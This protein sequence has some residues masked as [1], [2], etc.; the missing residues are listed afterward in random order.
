MGYAYSWTMIMGY[1]YS[2]MKIMGLYNKH[3]TKLTYSIDIKE[4]HTIQLKYV[5]TSVFDAAVVDNCRD[6]VEQFSM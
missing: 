1:A 6:Q 5:E 2:S 4:S 3:L